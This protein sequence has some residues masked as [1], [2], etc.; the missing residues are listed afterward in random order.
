M[1]VLSTKP[2]GDYTQHS[3][4]METVIKLT[5]HCVSELPMNRFTQLLLRPLYFTHIDVESITRFR[6]RHGLS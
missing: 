1:K 4:A 3:V 6:L 5:E 2:H